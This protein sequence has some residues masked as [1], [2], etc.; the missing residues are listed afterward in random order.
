[1]R[2][3]GILINMGDNPTKAAI[4]RK[5]AANLKEFGLPLSFVNNLRLPKAQTKEWLKVLTYEQIM[6]PASNFSVIEKI[7][8]LRI[9]EEALE[10]KLNKI[11]FLEERNAQNF[12]PCKLGVIV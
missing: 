11:K 12:K 3:A 2:K 10:R 8:H 5:R 9:L 6:R 7:H 1:M 4:E